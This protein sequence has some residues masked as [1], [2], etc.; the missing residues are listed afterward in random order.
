MG[1]ICYNENGI[2]DATGIPVAFFERVMRSV[3]IKSY[4]KVNL[5]LEIT[6]VE[7]GY[8]TL[9]SVVASIDLHD[10][11]VLKKRK[12]ALSAV[13]M[14]GM[15]SESIPPEKNNALKAAEAF[16]KTFGTDG[17]SI[18]VYKNIPIGA[19]L[20]GSSADIVGV[21]NGMA[22]LYGVTDRARLKGI[23]DE[24]GSD[25]GYMLSGGY[26]RL[27][28]RGERV[29]RLP[30]ANKLY[31]LLLCP[32]SSVSAK[33]CYRAYDDAPKTLEY[34]GCPAE[35]VIGFLQQ[36]NLEEGGRYLMNDLFRAAHSLN[37]E[38][39]KAYMEAESFSPL[40][41]NMTGSG[42]A[43]YALFESRELCEWA[44]SRYKGKFRAIV[45]ETVLPD[46]TKV[47]KSR[48]AWHNPFALSDEEKEEIQE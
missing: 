34:R 7:N 19:G 17:V 18:T 35:D 4:A 42:S 40:G 36:N 13:T 26:A 20:G 48:S 12:G 23:A 1:K 37:E 6:G 22:A 21:L 11:I 27:G 39:G 10:L 38:V 14:K 15:G 32:H 41:V 3:K 8:H 33:E 45:A 29:E 25:T 47:A 5:T 44:K 31:L 30:L 43:V 28:G 24:L 46:Y 9:D 2:N 16:S